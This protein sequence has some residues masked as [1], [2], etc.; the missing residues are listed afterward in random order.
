M[1][2]YQEYSKY[3]VE[4]TIARFLKS[5]RK[6]EFYTVEEITSKFLRIPSVELSD[7]EL[8]GLYLNA[9]KDNEDSKLSYDFNAGYSSRKP[10]KV[11]FLACQSVSVS[12]QT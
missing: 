11:I 3:K 7:I 5:T 6:Y 12:T 9:P 10:I 2:R 8:P 1:M 4:E